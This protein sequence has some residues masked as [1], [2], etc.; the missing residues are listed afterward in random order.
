MCCNTSAKELLD[1][2]GHFAKPLVYRHW[3]RNYMIDTDPCQQMKWLMESCM[4]QWVLCGTFSVLVIIAAF[5]LAILGA[6]DDGMAR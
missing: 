5:S 1:V 4:V 2:H 3:L 6:H